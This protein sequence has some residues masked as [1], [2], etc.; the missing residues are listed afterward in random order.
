MSS[1]AALLRIDR[2]NMIPKAVT[3]PVGASRSD[4]GNPMAN[5]CNDQIASAS[6]LRER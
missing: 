1:S 2:Q 3:S 5:T 4:H 6:G